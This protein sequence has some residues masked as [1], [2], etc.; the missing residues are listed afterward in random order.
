MALV[1]RT[2]VRVTNRQDSDNRVYPVLSI[3][4][5][6]SLLSDWMFSAKIDYFVLEVERRQRL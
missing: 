4:Y 2:K 3:L 5:S 1:M 6:L